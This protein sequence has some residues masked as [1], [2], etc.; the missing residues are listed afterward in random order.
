MTTDPGCASA[1]PGQRAPTTRE[2]T[3]SFCKIC[4]R[5]YITRSSFVDPV[6]RFF[7]YHFPVERGLLAVQK[8][9]ASG[10]AL[11]RP[12]RGAPDPLPWSWSHL[13]SSAT[14]T[15]SHHHTNTAS[16]PHNQP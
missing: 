16:P 11:G 1:P 8:G 14:T 9:A 12:N 3:A 13:L 4:F 10:A 15:S 2:M 7:A 6:F 5:A